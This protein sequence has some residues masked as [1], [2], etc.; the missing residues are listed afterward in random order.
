[1]VSAHRHAWVLAS[2]GRRYLTF[3]CGGCGAFRGGLARYLP[4]ELTGAVGERH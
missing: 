2:R 3:R 1:M 4:A